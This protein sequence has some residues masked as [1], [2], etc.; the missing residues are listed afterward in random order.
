M[1][2]SKTSNRLLNWQKRIDLY[3]DHIWGLQTKKQKLEEEIQERMKMIDHCDAV[4]LEKYQ[5]Q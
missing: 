3:N 5:N 2:Y 4:L 1:N